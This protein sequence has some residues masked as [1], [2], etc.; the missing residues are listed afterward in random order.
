M[1]MS[2]L[3]IGPIRN[4]DRAKGSMIQRLFPRIE[5]A[6]GGEKVDAEMLTKSEF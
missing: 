6:V 4:R 1:M 3:S 5:N 2:N